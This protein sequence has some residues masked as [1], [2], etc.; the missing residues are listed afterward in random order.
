M[1]SR[2]ISKTEFMYLFR[3]NFQN[4]IKERALRT[5]GF[6]SD[7]LDFMNKMS[8]QRKSYLANLVIDAIAETVYK[9]LSQANEQESIRIS[10]FDGMDIEAI[11]VPQKEKQNNLTGE[12]ITVASK[13]K[14]KASFTRTCVDKL[15]RSVR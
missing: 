5:G 13:I 6:F 8:E 7:I 9:S 3:K 2:K 1:D 10:L 11:Y 14:P 4:E 12:K 15:S